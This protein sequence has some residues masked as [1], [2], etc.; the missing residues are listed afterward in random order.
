MLSSS[1]PVLVWDID[2]LGV[3]AFPGSEFTLPELAY[4]GVTSAPY[5]DETCGIRIT[6]K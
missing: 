6:E 1:V 4:E 2:T 3:C 5:F